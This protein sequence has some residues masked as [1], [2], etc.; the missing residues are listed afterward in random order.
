MCSWSFPATRARTVKRP[1]TCR[2]TVLARGFMLGT[3]ANKEK[4][5]SGVFSYQ[6]SG[7]QSFPA[8]PGCDF[9]DQCQIVDQI[10]PPFLQRIGVDI[11]RRQKGS[12][13]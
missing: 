2:L 5:Y 12:E 1:G 10:L 3:R 7:F 9:P 13:E 6:G 11:W 8:R 4:R